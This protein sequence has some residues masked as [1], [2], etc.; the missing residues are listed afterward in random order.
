MSFKRIKNVSGSTLT[1]QGKTLKDSESYDISP[2]EE[3]RWRT[4]DEVLK[5]IGSGKVEVHSDK[6]IFSDPGEALQFFIGADPTPRDSDGS[7]LSRQKYTRTGWK[8]Q[9]HSI[10]FQTSNPESLHDH[11][12]TYNTQTFLPSGV[13]FMGAA[14]FIM[15][16]QNWEVTEDPNK[17]IVSL[18]TWEP[19]FSYE[20]IGAYLEQVQSPDQNVRLWVKAAPK[21]L[22]DGIFFAQ[23][24]INLRSL[25]NRKLQVDGR[26]P[27]M[28]KYNDPAPGS[29]ELHIVLVHP[30][31]YQHFLQLVLEVFVP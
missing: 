23:G 17:A 19:N 7:P 1:L 10:E 11:T 2:T 6:K 31:G 8:Y 4:N 20:I 14:K 24:G 30:E 15:L 13:G 28:L 22:Q 5:A 27:K 25:G 26:A 3:F 12:L 29:N 16:D 21:F 18:I 9:L